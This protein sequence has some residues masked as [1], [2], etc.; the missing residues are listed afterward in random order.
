[1][2]G[3]MTASGRMR[4]D[5]MR[6]VDEYSVSDFFVLRSPLLPFVEWARLAE[7]MITPHPAAT[8][9][10]DD[11]LERSRQVIAS[12]LAELIADPTVREAIFVA[13]PSLEG[14]LR[15]LSSSASEKATLVRNSLV[16]YIAR[17]AGR[18]TPFGLFAGCSVGTV[19]RHTSFQLSGRA[20]HRRTTKPD[21]S[22]ITTL[23]AAL[24]RDPALRAQL[25]VRANNSLYRVGDRVQFA[26][27]RAEG[28]FRNYYL[29]SAECDESLESALVVAADG[30]PI[31]TLIGHFVDAGAGV[32]E[33][34]HYVN[35]LVDSQVLVPELAPPVTSADILSDLI[36][37]LKPMAAGATHAGHL[38]RFQS[39]LASIDAAGLGVQA[40]E[41]RSAAESLRGLPVECD[42]A[43]LFQVD[44]VLGSQSLALGDDVVEE[45]KSGI[46][47]LHDA[48]G[49]EGTD[50]LESFRAAFRERYEDREVPLTEVLDE[51][52]GIGFRTA[53]GPHAGG[54]PLLKGVH[55]PSRERAGRR[56]V[57]DF[58]VVVQRRLID[59]L[60]AGL[61]EMVLTA[62]D[63]DGLRQREPRP[64]PDAFEVMLSVLPDRGATSP[65]VVL[66]SVTGP[67][68]AKMSGRFC[69]ADAAL[70]RHILDHLAAEESHRPE[71]LYC[72]I[73]HLPEGRLGNV[74]CRPVF[75]AYEIV[76]LGRSG[77]PVDH[78]I[79]VD[80][81][82]VS[83]QDDRIMLRSKSLGRE[84][85]PRLT[86]AHNTEF[87]AMSVYG[88]LAAV[89]SQGCAG[90]LS[91]Q[92]E[93]LQ[94]L[95]YL[96]RVRVGRVVLSRRTW[97]LTR[98]EIESACRG[99]EAERFRAVQ[100]LRRDKKFP[101][102][103]G[104]VEW[105]NILPIDLDNCVSIEVFTDTVAK[106]PSV[107]LREM[108]PG[109]DDLMVVGPEGR[110]CHEMLLP[111]VRP[112]AP[113]AQSHPVR[114]HAIAGD[115]APSSNTPRVRLPGSDWLFVKIY[116][117]A[118]LQDQLLQ[119]IAPMA[120]K[121]I[122]EGW[123]KKWF[124]VRYAD[125]H[126]H[127]RLRFQ[128]QPSALFAKWLPTITA[129]LERRVSQGVLW[130]VQI[131][132]YEREIARYGGSQAMEICESIFHADSIAVCSM[133]HS[134]TERED[135]DARWRVAL[136]GMHY[137]FED[138][139]LN[140][141][142]RFALA[143]ECAQ[144]WSRELGL[145]GAFRRSLLAKY[146]QERSAIERLISCRGDGKGAYEAS[147]Q[148][149]A[150]RSRRLS[151]LFAELRE[152][153]QHGKLT[154]PLRMVVESVVHM[155]V[156]R[157][158]RIN[159]REH[160]AVLYHFLDRYY[161]SLLARD[162]VKGKARGD[163]SIDL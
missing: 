40:D 4:T 5:I 25:V 60:A 85:I 2:L 30:V 28:R 61:D 24:I 95:P 41:Y 158:I 10:G 114:R 46:Q 79:T 92:W 76:Y 115:G 146:R 121:A 154:A 104:L 51:E 123:M 137:L 29:V 89:Q 36:A 9:E 94:H 17:M 141:A 52:I 63:T 1:M 21:M 26:E 8:R 15:S 132:T 68:G 27:A 100:Q 88:F 19:G 109:P 111:F 107:T 83:L 43:R 162:G 53:N 11:E 82:V 22:Y 14:A 93:H 72:E 84:L 163:L 160:E 128:G 75:R 74:I 59:A 145:S 122:D 156:N 64:L 101:R 35:D 98:P 155:H 131:D 148:A 57:S 50:S 159:V 116:C 153:G 124:F 18:S 78:Q 77:A 106:H 39:A 66:Q 112:T 129:E 147:N 97:R 118:V 73:V 105:D 23:V 80:D 102:H 37:Q 31:A 33:A 12:R 54:S 87:K 91:W 161:D 69:H 151:P 81:I 70:H 42:L 38:S 117:G 150:E 126:K 157:M 48:F 86:T 133:L 125:P 144:R 139:G 6:M 44:L 55:F 56:A 67:S 58:G 108:F 32:E 45:V 7:G 20:G 140:L 90:A 34:T 62:E 13:S 135:A 138:C 16:K 134:A 99:T 149:L 3:C 96:P 47:F 103:V 130:K 143:H 152:L 71:A 120:Q 142:S 65:R 49:H 136:A 110:Y 113:N 127:L 119:L